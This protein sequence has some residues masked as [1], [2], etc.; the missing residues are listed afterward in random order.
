M[1]THEGQRLADRYELGTTLGTGGMAEVVEG[2]DTKLGRRVAIKLLHSDLA[3][4]PS[5][6]ERFRR[7]AVA[8]AS[9]NHPNIVSVYDTGEEPL[10]GPGSEHSDL[11]PRPFI[12]MEY[13]DGI[14]LRQLINSGRRLLPERVIEMVQGVLAALDYS[15][16][17]GIVH[18]DIK[19]GNVML[20][21]SSEVKVMDFGIARALADHSQTVTHGPQVLGTAQYLSPEQAKGEVVDSR[22]DLYSTGCLLYELLTGKPPFT[23]ESPV[24]V[25]YQHVSEPVVPATQLDP[26][27]P[28]GIDAV[29]AR[30]LAKR[31]DD[32]Y[33]S[34]A[35]FSDDL[36]RVLAGTLEATTAAVPAAE[37]T[38]MFEP[39]KEAAP[40]VMPSAAATASRTRRPALMWGGFA[41][42]V[43]GVAALVLLLGQLL[44][45]TGKTD[46]V[47]V[48]D[49]TGLSLA[50]AKAKL[51]KEGLKVGQQDTR[52][53]TTVP[54]GTVIEQS[55]IKDEQ[56]PKGGSVDVIVSG[57]SGSIKVPD[58]RNYPTIN[59]VRDA[60]I[61]AGLNLGAVTYVDSDLP[62]DTV[63]SQNPAAGYNL[64][65][66]Q[67]VS[68]EVSSGKIAIPDV[69]G[70]TEAQA[71]AILL[72]AGFQ[73]SVDYMVDSTQ[74]N[75]VVLSQAPDSTMKGQVGSLISLVIN[76]TAPSASPTDSATP[77]P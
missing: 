55:P 10:T 47:S 17:N 67:R 15:H 39:V 3:R 4:D 42:S 64:A 28:G 38:T 49:V 40:L 50:D 43:I 77:T 12:V 59:D 75:G 61:E 68:V 24:S 16:R 19:P 63:L 52:P 14:T 13:V 27:L 34:A 44:T 57:G 76:G 58:L 7:E 8:A 26:T 30:A 74:P 21:R 2:H 6:H 45:G 37:R 20:T 33:Q 1:T 70:K 62:K 71:R 25:A 36:T 51:A 29:L 31:P 60:L 48:P 46:L 23:G 11:V 66:G 22:S 65:P 53:S 69:I 72:N 32:R 41:A 18:R 5:F 54:Q 9:L 56:L 35:E 73:P